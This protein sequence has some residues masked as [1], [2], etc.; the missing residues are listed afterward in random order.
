MSVLRP[1]SDR[2]PDPTG[3]FDPSDVACR[4]PAHPPTPS[5]GVCPPVPPDDYFPAILTSCR[6]GGA[7]ALPRPRRG[8][9]LNPESRDSPDDRQQDETDKQ[10]GN[11][12]DGR[13]SVRHVLIL[14]SLAD[15]TENNTSI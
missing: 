15:F 3:R 10:T 6:K 8:L 4:A 5:P 7:S 14:A 12:G 13:D 1:A 9:V 2:S 11:D